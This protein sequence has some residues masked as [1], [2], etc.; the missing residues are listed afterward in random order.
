MAKKKR[1]QSAAFMRSINP[2]LR[3][4]RTAKKLN[5]RGQTAMVKHRRKS[6]KRSHR[7]SGTKGSFLKTLLMAAGYGAVRNPIANFTT[8]LINKVVATPWNDHIGNGIAG[9]AA[10][11]FG[12]G[13]V[14]E[15]GKVVVMVE[16]ASAATGINFG[17]LTGQSQT[18]SGYVFN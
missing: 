3:H 8:P 15:V 17:N 9:L 12:K 13:M 1:G 14:K 4:R 16:V 7:S 11:K 2:N 10:Y 18:S 6:G 5:K